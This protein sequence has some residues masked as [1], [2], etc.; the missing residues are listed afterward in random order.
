MSNS[1]FDSEVLKDAKALFSYE[2]VDDPLEHRDVLLGFGNHSEYVAKRAAELYLEGWAKRILF[3][4]GFGRVTRNIW[5]VPEAERFTDVATGM[6]VPREAIL[7]DTTSTNTGENISHSKQ[8]LAEAGL[9]S[10]SAIVVELPFR[11]RRTRSALEAQWPELDFIMAS[12]TLSFEEF[13]S[14]YK[15]EGPIGANEFL[16][17][18]AGDVQ[19]IIEYGRRGWQTPQ[20]IPGEVMAAYKRLVEAGFTSQMLKD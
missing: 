19:R 12:P 6:G 17:I 13:L 14:I 16:S 5:H 18:L 10:T 9:D 15:N 3:T 7:L 2:R 1:E 4:G 8:L 11:G 20:D